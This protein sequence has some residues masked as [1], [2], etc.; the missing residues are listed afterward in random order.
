MVCV[1][2]CVYLCVYNAM[3]IIKM[4]VILP[5][6]AKW[7]DME[8]IMLSEISWR[9][10]NTVYYHLY[11]KSKK[12]NKLVNITKKKQTHRRTNWWL[13]V[14]RGKEDGQDRGKGLSG[15]N[16]YVQN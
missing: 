5:F 13:P 16:Y 6:E 1:C 2:V 4:N 15:T 8:G 10:T 12:Y 3:L 7:M 9:A 14:E 11:V